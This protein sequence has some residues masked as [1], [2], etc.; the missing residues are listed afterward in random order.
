MLAQ[1][2]F[3]LTFPGPAWPSCSRTCQ[4]CFYFYNCGETP[5]L[6]GE[7]IETKEPRG[8]LP[9][10]VHENTENTEKNCMLKIFHTRIEQR[11]AVECT[12]VVAVL[13]LLKKRTVDP[14]SGSTVDDLNRIF[15]RRGGRGRRQGL[16]GIVI[17][18]ASFMLF[19][20]ISAHSFPTTE[21]RVFQANG[22]E[23]A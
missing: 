11:W 16:P 22:G 10:S 3:S 4:D 7:S 20:Y 14:G 15:D 9:H 18:S 13:R 17:C 5:G 19:A 8:I 21:W 1:R 2:F 23:G 12:V 6:S